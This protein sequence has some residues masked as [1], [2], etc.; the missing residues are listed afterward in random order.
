[1]TTISNEFIKTIAAI[2]SNNNINKV[3]F[4]SADSPTSDFNLDYLFSYATV[5]KSLGV[6]TT[7]S[8]EPVNSIDNYI[9]S[10]TFDENYVAKPP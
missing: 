10:A 9:I 1:M 3:V 7:T 2:A 8:S 5:T 6:K 4:V